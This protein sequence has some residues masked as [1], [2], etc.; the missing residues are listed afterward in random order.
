MV[1]VSEQ[2]LNKQTSSGDEEEKSRCWLNTERNLQFESHPWTFQ[3]H[4]NFQKK[5][6]T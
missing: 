5:V 6:E 1:R 2:K 4:V 3:L